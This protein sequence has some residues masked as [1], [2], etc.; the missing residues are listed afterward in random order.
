MPAAL[1][2]IGGLAL[3]IGGAELLIRGAARLAVSA[4]LTPLV[5]GLT[6]VAFGTGAPELAVGLSSGLGQAPAVGIGNVVGSNIANVLLVLGLSAL[7]APLRVARRLIRLDVPVMLAAS[8]LVWVLA[9]DGCIGRLEGGALVLAAAGYTAFVL[10][11]AR[12]EAAMSRAAAELPGLPARPVWWRDLALVL[13]GL[14]LL[15]LGAQALV[16]AAVQLAV[17]FGVSELVVGLTVVAVGTSLP[18]LAT[19]VVAAARGHG[20]MAVGNVVGSNIFNLLVVLGAS[21]VVAGGLPVSAAARRFD[22]PVLTA[23][24]FACL[25]VFFAGHRIARWEGGLFFV[26]YLAYVG[27][28]LLDG[29]GHR[30]APVFGWAMM[31]FVLPLTAVTLAVLTVRAWRRQRRG[32]VHRYED[33]P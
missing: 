8:V 5:V 27:Y 2:L 3:L 30:A 20:Q 21:A 13:G 12:R 7:V 1:G 29:T 25:P 19:S 11:L 10:R 15:V 4:G 24:A 17:G 33:D 9:G 23:V 16:T 6:V 32:C 18:E 31:S 26:Y 14:V 28:L 22:L